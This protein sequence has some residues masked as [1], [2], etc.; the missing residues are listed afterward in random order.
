MNPQ[1]APIAPEIG[2]STVDAPLFYSLRASFE[3]VEK[4]VP[5]AYFNKKWMVSGWTGLKY[6]VWRQPLTFSFNGN[7]LT[8]LASVSYR[9]KTQKGFIL[10]PP[11][12]YP[13]R[14]LTTRRCGNAKSPYFAS[15]TA[16]NVFGYI[17]G[18][19]L[20]SKT[21]NVQSSYGD[22]GCSLK[23]GK[24]LAADIATRQIRQSMDAGAEVINSG[25]RQ[26]DFATDAE[27]RWRALSRPINLGGDRWLAFKPTE[28][29]LTPP[30]GEQNSIVT[31][32]HI[33]VSPTVS[34]S[35][36]ESTIV[37]LPLPN[38]TGPTNDFRVLLENALTLEDVADTLEQRLVGTQ[39]KLGDK[40]IQITALGVTGVGDQVAVRL[41]LAG[42]VAGTIYFQGKVSSD[43]ASKTIAFTKLSLTS[44]SEKL[45]LN[46]SV[47]WIKETAL[48]SDLEANSKWD[49]SILL[50]TS[51]REFA[52]AMS[53]TVDNG[54]SL[55]SSLAP[56]SLV[57]AFAE[58]DKITVR[59]IS[60]GNVKLVQKN[61]G[62]RN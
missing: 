6:N 39:Y 54:L 2:A 34:V 50:S 48:F 53:Q 36:P 9:I 46:S 31:H 19:K 14:L 12:S 43:A 41:R 13:V 42:D 28:V 56:E 22:K 23:L 49:L 1:P 44:E 24:E 18:W 15:T 17:D 60:H 25:I 20:N 51:A 3:G 10:E 59:F 32:V 21:Q 4:L 27:Q 57:Q 52:E 29:S 37:P 61:Q 26:I 45:L 33:V 30:V 55:Q 5:L 38:S 7:L 8:T 40:S 11:F 16:T 62:L 58:K 35:E 47:G